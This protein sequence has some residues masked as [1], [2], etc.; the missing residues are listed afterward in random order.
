MNNRLIRILMKIACALIVVI[1]FGWLGFQFQPKSFSVSSEII[2][3]TEYQQ[4]PDNLPS[5]VYKHFRKVFED[6]VPIVESSIVWGKA[7]M[8]ISGIWAPARFIAYYIP[9]EGFYRYMEVT[10]YGIP[11]FKGYDLYTEEKAEFC[12]VGKVETGDKIVQGQNLALWGEA[13]WSPSFFITDNRLKWK[14]VDKDNVNLSIPYE[15]NYQ[16]LTIDFNSESGL[17]KT[18]EAMRYRGQSEEKF[19]WRIDCLEWELFN[20]VLIPVKTSLT[21][22]GDKG[23]WSYWIIEGIQ[24]NTEIS[25]GFEEEILNREN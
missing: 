15:D 11:V 17:I 22:E 16:N 18:I 7:K 19:L 12:M 5:Q 24:Y 20:N 3:T 10:W 9:E 8:N 1:F 14:E 21:W 4:L 13:V 6:K 25:K 2:K 23:P